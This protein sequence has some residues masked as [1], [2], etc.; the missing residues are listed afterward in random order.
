VICYLCFSGLK[1]RAAVNMA[2]AFC[3]GTDLAALLKSDIGQPMAAIFFNSFGKNATLG[4]WTLVA[5][6]QLSFFTPVLPF[7]N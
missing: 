2:L 6:V 4:I 1:S 7:S 3:M 5:I